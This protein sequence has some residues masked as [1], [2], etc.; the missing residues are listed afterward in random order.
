MSQSRN[1]Q[2]SMSIRSFPI[3]LALIVFSLLPGLMAGCTSDSEPRPVGQ[4]EEGALETASL[5]PEVAG[6]PPQIRSLQLAPLRPRPDELVEARVDIK[7]SEGNPVDLDYEWKLA[8]RPVRARSQAVRFPAARKG[9]RIEVRVTATDPNGL[10]SVASAFARIGN[11]PPSLLGVDIS[12]ATREEGVSVLQ[13]SVQTHDPDGDDLRLTYE[14]RVN[15]RRV[16]EQQ[17]FLDI[18]ELRRG[19]EVQVVVMADDGDDQSGSLMSRV[20]E[21][22]NSAPRITSM[23]HNTSSDTS[24][25]YQVQAEDPDLD[26]G[27]IYSLVEAPRGMAMGRL[28]GEL[29]WNPGPD[30]AGVHTVTIQVEDR[31]GGRARQTFELT[32]RDDQPSQEMASVRN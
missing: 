13:V 2:S 5:A 17:S 10:T 18:R 31:H 29:S 8:D 22:E 15:G 26:R 24:F 16:P 12:R 32:I 20:F 4:G 21:V 14:W 28:G 6:A 19:D 7:A 25:F 3:G 30:Q 1:R 9:D 11:Q 27:L 23:P